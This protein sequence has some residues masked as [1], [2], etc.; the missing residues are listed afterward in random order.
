[1]ENRTYRLSATLVNSWLYYL[2]NK[3]P[4][5]FEKFKDDLQN[6][7]VPNKWTR[8]GVKFEQ[9]V[10]E[11][12]HGMLSKL[13][14]PLE[15]Q[16]K[17]RKLIHAA[18]LDIEIVGK[19]DAIDSARQRIYDIKRVDVFSADKYDDNVQHLFYFFLH[20]QIQ[21]FYY[22]V[23]DGEGDKINKQNV[24]MFTRPNDVDLQVLVEQYATGFI[25]FLI[26]NDLLETYKQFHINK[27]CKKVD[28]TTLEGAEQNTNEQTT[29]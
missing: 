13:I 7:F 19:P 4:Q 14:M 24:I 11:G 27:E 10:N 3:T 5:Q 12:K 28:T 17:L 18:G 15:K 8:R 25:N 6:K 22:L 26:E 23:V 20:D 9:E 16:T 29:D 1:M 21:E 2:K